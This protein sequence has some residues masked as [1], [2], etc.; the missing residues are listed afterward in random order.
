MCVCACVCIVCVQLSLLVTH[1]KN[2]IFDSEMYRDWKNLTSLLCVIIH[3]QTD[4]KFI[5]F[6]KLI[7]K[8][9]LQ[10]NPLAQNLRN[11]KCLQGEIRQLAELGQTQ[12]DTGRKN[13]AR[14]VNELVEA[15]C[16]LVGECR[17]LGSFRYRRVYTF[18]KLFS[19][20]PTRSTLR[21]QN[22][23]LCWKEQEPLTRTF[24]FISSVEQKPSPK[25]RVVS[26]ANLK[27]LG[28]THCSWGTENT[29]YS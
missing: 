24:S 9:R 16:G 13:P 23:S 29:L 10:D 20:S 6:L 12:S 28:R 8:L 4:C 3:C 22:S 18:S 11:E 7:R 14:I 1:V 25:R 17:T 27:M 2:Q 26:T 19:R 5:T 15:A 21:K